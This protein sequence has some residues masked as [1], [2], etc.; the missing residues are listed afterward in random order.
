MSSFWI[1]EEDS[2]IYD[3]MN[4]GTK[5]AK[6]EWVYFLNAGDTFVN[7]HT[8]EN[9]ILELERN[10]NSDVVYGD[11][12]H[13]KSGVLMLRK[14]KEPCNIHRMYFCHQS[15]FI[16]R[17]LILNYLY[18]TKYKMSA[19]LKFFKQVYLDGYKFAHLHIPI[20]IYDKSGVSNTKR[21]EGLFENVKVIKEIDKGYIKLISITRL[22][23][24]IYSRKLLKREKS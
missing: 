14:A 4:K 15:A 17:F 16:K 2:G 22:Y 8:L 19:D 13:N 23:F 11:I 1:S 3:A 21:N 7:T 24:T 10:N 5:I 20:V 9:A 18:D 6:G 12:L